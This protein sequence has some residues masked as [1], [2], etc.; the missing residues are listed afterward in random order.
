MYPRKRRCYRKYVF[1]QNLDKGLLY[2]NKMEKYYPLKPFIISN[3]CGN[4]ENR[5]PNIFWKLTYLPDFS[6]QDRN[7]T[8]TLHIQPAVYS[9]P[10]FQFFVLERI[11]INHFRRITINL[12]RHRQSKLYVYMRNGYSK[13]HTSLLS[14]PWQFRF[15]TLSGK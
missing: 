8:K 6:D 15:F 13:H 9:D 10:F 7:L 5:Y 2:F 3:K 1:K 12:E 4:I 14:T 11:T